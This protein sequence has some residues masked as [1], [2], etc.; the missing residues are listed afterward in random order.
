MKIIKSIDAIY[1]EK[2]EG[3]DVLYYLFS[4]Y[5]LHYNEQA[6]HTTQVWH[7]HDY[8]SESLY[9]I[10]GELVAKWHE[11]GRN[12]DQIV[13]NGDLIE[14]EDT[15]HTFVNESDQ[16]V[17]FIVIKQIS[18]GKDCREILKNDKVIDEQL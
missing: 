4:D 15:P 2:P 12:F 14:T 10:D 16:I 13:K 6:P 3:T 17:K 1:L 7:H 11:N 8:I 5:E 9:M 18:S